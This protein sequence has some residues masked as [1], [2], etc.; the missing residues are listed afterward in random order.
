MYHPHAIDPSGGATRPVRGKPEKDEPF[1]LW[2]VRSTAPT[3]SLQARSTISE[4]TLCSSLDAQSACPC[5]PGE[6]MSCGP[7]EEGERLMRKVIAAVL[8]VSTLVALAASSSASASADPTGQFNHEAGFRVDTVPTSD[9]CVIGF[10][11]GDVLDFID[12]SLTDMAS[13]SF[14]LKNVCGTVHPLANYGTTSCRSRKAPSRFPHST[15]ADPE[16]PRAFDYVAQVEG[17]NH[18]RSALRESARRIA[19]R[20]S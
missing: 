16:P 9:P 20:R 5:G 3:M 13:V 6:D 4:S 14:G 18:R 2:K 11:G 17:A 7:G 8:C 15:T 10:A 1:G 12:R 19:T